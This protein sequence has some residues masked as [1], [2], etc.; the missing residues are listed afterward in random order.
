MA[1]TMPWAVHAA[2]ADQRW[3]SAAAHANTPNTPRPNGSTAQL[4]SRLLLLLLL[5]LLAHLTACADA[6]QHGAAP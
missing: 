1:H 6:G 4:R 5:L 3:V 2:T